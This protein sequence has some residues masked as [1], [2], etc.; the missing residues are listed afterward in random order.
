[1]SGAEIGQK[2]VNGP[3]V[4]TSRL[5]MQRNAEGVDG[6]V[7]DSGQW[8]EEP[9]ASRAVHEEITGSGRMC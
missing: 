7:Q 6:A 8:M 2:L 5:G 9:R 3:A 1:M 4:V